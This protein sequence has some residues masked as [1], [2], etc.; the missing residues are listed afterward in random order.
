MGRICSKCGKNV[1]DYSFCPKCGYTVCTGCLDPVFTPA[2]CLGFCP[3]CGSRL[4]GHLSPT[5]MITY[6]SSL[7]WK[8]WGWKIALV[9]GIVI[10]IA[11]ILLFLWFI[12]SGALGGLIGFLFCWLNGKYKFFKASNRLSSWLDN[13]FKFIHVP[14]KFIFFIVVILF[15]IFTPIGYTIYQPAYYVS[16]ALIGFVIGY[17]LA[18]KKED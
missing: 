12:V 15:L 11:I 9:V 14:D 10:V 2:S 8:E 3:R 5:G 4:E 13:T 7:L 1:E 6:P 17:W 16:A 18:L